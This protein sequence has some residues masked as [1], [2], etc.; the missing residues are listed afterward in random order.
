MQNKKSTIHLFVGFVGFGKTTLAKK[1]AKELSA[2]CFTHDDLMVERYGRNPDDFQTKYK[3]I[4]DFIKAK[5]AECIKNGQ[6]V[7]LD[8]GFWTHAKRLEYYNWAK[9]LTNNVLFHV[10]VCDMD[11]AKQRVLKRTQETP[12]AL[13]IDES[14]FDALSN[15]YEPWSAQDNFPVVFHESK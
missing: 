9:S 3:I 15:K 2:K 10:V 12:D 7:I 6:N 4:D 14:I 11:T 13:F 5:S 1:L 8:Y